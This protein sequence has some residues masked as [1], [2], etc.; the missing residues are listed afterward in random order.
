MTRVCETRP[1]RSRKT[2]KDG[3][4]RFVSEFDLQR[5]RAASSREH[6]ALLVQNDEIIVI[7]KAKAYRSYESFVFGLALVKG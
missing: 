1:E 3:K 5:E 4:I 6:C 7:I 2:L